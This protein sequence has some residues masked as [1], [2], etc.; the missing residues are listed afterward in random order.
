MAYDENFSKM[1]LT[2][3]A[4]SIARMAPFAAQLGAVAKYRAVLKVYQIKTM[5]L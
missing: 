5:F 3:S 2:A 4:T 1:L